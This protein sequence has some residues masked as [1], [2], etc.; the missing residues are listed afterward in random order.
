MKHNVFRCAFCEKDFADSDLQKEHV[1]RHYKTKRLEKCDV[2][3]LLHDKVTHRTHFARHKLLPGVVQ[4]VLE[5]KERPAEELRASLP[6]I[7]EALKAMWDVKAKTRP[8]PMTVQCCMCHNKFPDEAA[9]NNHMMIHKVELYNKQCER[10]EMKRKGEKEK[11]KEPPKEVDPSLFCSM[12]KVS[13]P[14]T[15]YVEQHIKTFHAAAH[16]RERLQQMRK[17]LY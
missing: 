2:C 6:S 10:G 15:K 5:I 14:S 1:N 8:G 4:K 3:D 7:S 16:Q 9:L 11:S 13:F 12:C 17:N